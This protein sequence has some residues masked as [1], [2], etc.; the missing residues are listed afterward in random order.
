MCVGLNFN[1]TNP[2]NLSADSYFAV[3][4]GYFTSSYTYRLRCP[5]SRFSM[6]LTLPSAS[7]LAI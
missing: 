7:S 2:T 4:G 5:T 6:I 1:P 3:K